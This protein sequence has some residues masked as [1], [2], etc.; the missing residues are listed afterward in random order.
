[1]RRVVFRDGDKPACVLV[2]SVDDSRSHNAANP[3][4]TVSAMIKKR[5]YKR[6]VRVA[7]RRM[8][9]HSGRFIYN[10]Y[11]VVLINYV[12]R[13][14]FGQR[15]VGFGFGQDD[16]DRIPRAKLQIFCRRAS[17]YQNKTVFT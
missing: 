2:D 17:V 13:Y 16:L 3:R 11:V 9:D 7:R 1:M 8:N 10:Y 12:K 5:V 14:I 4:K 15:L 6:S